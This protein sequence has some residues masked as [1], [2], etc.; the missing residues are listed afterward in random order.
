MI[1]RLKKTVSEL[2]N[3]DLSLPDLYKLS[4]I[5]KVLVELEKEVG[6][7]EKEMK[8]FIERLMRK[9]VRVKDAKETRRPR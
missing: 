1:A 6:G 3:Q 7:S 8:E 9:Y 2:L 4:Q 5:L